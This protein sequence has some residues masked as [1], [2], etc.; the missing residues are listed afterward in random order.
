MLI[1]NFATYLF[2]KIDSFFEKWFFMVHLTEKREITLYNFVV[3]GS[4]RNSLSLIDS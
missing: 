1:P 4:T 3:F 2:Q